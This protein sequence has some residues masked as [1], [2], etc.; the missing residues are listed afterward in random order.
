MAKL[1]TPEERAEQAD[2]MREIRKL[3]GQNKRGSKQQVKFVE[4]YVKEP[5]ATKAF[6]AA[7]GMSKT[8][9]NTRSQA[10]R[11]LHLPEV[12]AMIQKVDSSIALA[13]QGSVDKL[14]ELRDEGDTRT[15]LF[16][17]KGLLDTYADMMRRQEKN[18]ESSA[19]TNNILITGLSD[20][21]LVHRISQFGT[22]G[23]VPGAITPNVQEGADQANGGGPGL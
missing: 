21:E 5:N 2:K 20:D 23:T 22:Q 4:E 18:A 8:P 13:A 17:A 19:T 16:A 7:Y 3:R 14:V 10:W 6:I 11:V 1:W 15:A 12:Q 9:S